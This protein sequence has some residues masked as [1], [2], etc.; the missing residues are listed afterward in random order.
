LKEG[1]ERIKDIFETM[2]RLSEKLSTRLQLAGN[3]AVIVR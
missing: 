2:R 3:E 1:D